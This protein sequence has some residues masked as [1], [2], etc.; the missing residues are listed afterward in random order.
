M[1]A[2]ITIIVNITIHVRNTTQW[3][4]IQH[5]S[6]VPVPMSCSSSRARVF[7]C[8]G[9]AHVFWL[10]RMASKLKQHDKTPSNPKAKLGP[11]GYELQR[12][13]VVTTKTGVPYKDESNKALG[14]CVIFL[15][16][17][18]HM[19]SFRRQ[20]LL[21]VINRKIGVVTT[22]SSA[23]THCAVAIPF[24]R[25]AATR[26]LNKYGVPASCQLVS[27]YFICPIADH[28]SEPDTVAAPEALR[29]ERKLTWWNLD[30][31]GK[32]KE[33]VGMAGTTCK[34]E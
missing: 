14:G 9:T 8:Y 16:P 4:R 6:S 23:S 22:D 15:L 12:N 21:P 32:E 31:C 11:Y 17:C 18:A 13:S 24:A 1:S 3:K 25:P 10:L 2:I 29:L 30:S 20:L 7:C 19:S 26:L 5:T 34:G 27:E 33:L 28:R